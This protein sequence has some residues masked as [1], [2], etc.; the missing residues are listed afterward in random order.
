MVTRKK[1]VIASFHMVGDKVL[2]KGIKL[3]V[4]EVKDNGYYVATSPTMTVTVD[5][6][7]QLE[8]YN[9]D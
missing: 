8:K 3:T 1:E 2:W 6:P 7:E 9:A 5:T 4:V